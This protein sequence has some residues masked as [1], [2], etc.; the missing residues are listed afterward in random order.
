MKTFQIDII[1][2]VKMSWCWLN[3]IVKDFLS[4]TE[5]VLDL[6]SNW[7]QSLLCHHEKEFEQEEVKASPLSSI[8][9]QVNPALKS[10]FQTFFYTF[11]LVYQ[12]WTCFNSFCLMKS[13]DLQIRKLLLKE[14]NHFGLN[15]FKTQENSKFSSSITRLYYCHYF[16]STDL[17][18]CSNNRIYVLRI[19]FCSHLFSKI[20]NF[21]LSY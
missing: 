10:G 20:S 7:K 4:T 14:V 21:H 3:L 16:E 17:V 9:G 6:S 5:L 2:E 18:L 12:L 11:K 15:S 1:L 8:P 19:S 13:S